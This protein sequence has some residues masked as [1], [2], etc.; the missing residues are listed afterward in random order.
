MPGAEHPQAGLPLRAALTLHAQ[1]GQHKAGGL[2]E[3]ALE[4]AAEPL[5]FLGVVELV[6]HG[7]HVHRKLTL[8]VY[9][10]ERI[11]VS[12]D[13]CFDIDRQPPRQRFGKLQSLAVTE[14]IVPI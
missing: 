7:V 3:T 12:R 10:G 8:F 5:A 13:H 6:I 4:Y 1:Q 14:S 9:V 2:A 11:F